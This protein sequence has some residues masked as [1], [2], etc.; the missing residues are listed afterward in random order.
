MQIIERIKFARSLLKKT[1][2]DFEKRF[3]VSEGTVYRWEQGTSEA[4]YK[5]IEFCEYIIEEMQFCPACNGTGILNKKQEYLICMGRDG[6]RMI[7]PHFTGGRCITGAAINH[8]YL[9]EKVERIAE[10]DAQGKSEEPYELSTGYRI[11]QMRLERG[12]TQAQFASHLNVSPTMVSLWE[13]NK[14]KPPQKVLEW[15][16][17]PS[18]AS[19]ATDI[20]G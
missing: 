16:L 17:V 18:N 3:N 11:R 10:K 6:I 20:A 13:T 12:E 19:E 9:S 8:P 4:P 14:V 15:Q 2:E 1:R 7:L 5:V